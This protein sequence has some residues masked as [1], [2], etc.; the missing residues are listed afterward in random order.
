MI[1]KYDYKD[2]TGYKEETDKR[3]FVQE[4][5]LF[6]TRCANY[7]ALFANKYGETEVCHVTSTQQATYFCPGRIKY[8]CM[9]VYCHSCHI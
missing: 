4:T 3:Y 7:S 9:H 6:G 5:E 1:C 8:N 2:L